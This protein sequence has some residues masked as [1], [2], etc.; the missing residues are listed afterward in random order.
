MVVLVDQESFQWFQFLFICF[1]ETFSNQVWF[2]H[3]TCLF[4]LHDGKELT[5]N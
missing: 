5:E 1:F 4:Q 3:P 2:H